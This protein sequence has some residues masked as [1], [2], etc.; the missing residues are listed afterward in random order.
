VLLKLLLS[1][2]LLLCQ[3]RLLLH[4]L[5]CQERLLLKLLLVSLL[6]CV[7]WLHGDQSPRRRRGCFLG[8][9]ELVFPASAEP[10]C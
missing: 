9:P 7:R 8:E 4:L 10:G 5:L 6:I 3:E 2:D 1:L